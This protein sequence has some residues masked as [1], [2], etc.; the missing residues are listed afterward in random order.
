ME[1]DEIKTPKHYF[2]RGGVEC[3]KISQ[4]FNF[5][6]GNVIKYIWRAG[7]KSNESLLKDLRKAREYIDFE[8]L[9]VEEEETQNVKSL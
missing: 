2:K 7:H 6:L 9:R 4:T 8:I 3:I 5:N 1:N